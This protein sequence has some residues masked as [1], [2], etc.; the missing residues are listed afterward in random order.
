MCES[1]I[2]RCVLSFVDHWDC[3]TSVTVYFLLSKNHELILLLE[4][5]TKYCDIYFLFLN[6]SHWDLKAATIYF[7]LYEWS[8]S[9]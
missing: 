2:V 6:K 8:H 5:L 9:K 4:K 1:M 3:S 7:F